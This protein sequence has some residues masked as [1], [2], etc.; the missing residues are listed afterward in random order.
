MFYNKFNSVFL[1]TLF[2]MF[3]CGDN[4]SSTSTNFSSDIGQTTAS[5]VPSYGLK[6][7][8]SGLK[9]ELAWTAYKTPNK[10]PVIGSFKNISLTNNKEGKSLEEMLEGAKFYIDG[11]TVTSGD[12]SRDGTLTLFFFKRLASPEIKG[13]FGKFENNK[14]MISI[15]LDG[16]TITKEF[17]YKLEKSTLTVNGSIDLLKDFDCQRA[18]TS[19]HRACFDLHEGKT[20]TEIDL[21]AII[22]K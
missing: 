15:T 19:L 14:V 8:E 13:S 10:V 3:A 12:S 2:L 16:K 9:K 5:S 17:S 11:T 18:F 7:E 21:T 22:S 20:W 6:G 1:S 4:K